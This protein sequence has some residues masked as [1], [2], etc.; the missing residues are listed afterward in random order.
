M[1]KLFGEKDG[2]K[3]IGLGLVKGNVDLLK[4]DRPIFFDCRQNHFDLDGTITITYESEQF[5]E[6]AGEGNGLRVKS[7]FGK[8][9]FLLVINDD[10]IQTLKALPGLK[11][12]HENILFILFYAEDDESMKKKIDSFGIVGPQTI[13]THEGYSPVDKYSFHN[14]N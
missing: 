7:A 14:N 10:D 12:S 6:L 1:Y 11:I 3:I 9:N 5:K 8:Y 4:Q 13:V 2:K